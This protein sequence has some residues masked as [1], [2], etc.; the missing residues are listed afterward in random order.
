[1]KET[2]D[3]LGPSSNVCVG[4]RHTKEQLKLIFPGN[5]IIINILPAIAI[6]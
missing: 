3:F 2:K 1:M 5:Y 4:F 6:E